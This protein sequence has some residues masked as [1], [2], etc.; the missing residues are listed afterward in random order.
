MPV[1]PGALEF[2]SLSITVVQFLFTTLTCLFHK[3]C[4]RLKARV[5]IYAYHHVRLLPPSP[6]VV[7]QPKFTRVEGVGIVMQSSAVLGPQVFDYGVWSVLIRRSART[8]RVARDPSAG[9]RRAGSRSRATEPQSAK[10]GQS[11][12]L[13]AQG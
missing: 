1:Y 2:L 3:K 9:R 10:A 13:G 11:V 4:N 7:M 12:P 5:V 8:F 6:L